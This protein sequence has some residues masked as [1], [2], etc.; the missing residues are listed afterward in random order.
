[1]IPNQAVIRN[2]FRTF[3]LI[4]SERDD[5]SPTKGST[6][7]Q[8]RRK[9]RPLQLRVPH[10]SSPLFVRSRLWGQALSA[11]TKRQRS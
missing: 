6:G 5:E 9:A 11:P 2:P 4:V 8:G 1:M 10:L 7:Y 3:W